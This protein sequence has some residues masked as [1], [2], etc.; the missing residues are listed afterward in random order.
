MQTNRENPKFL[1]I[2]P[3][4]ENMGIEYLSASLK[5]NNY[6][7]DLLFLPRPY[8]NTAFKIFNINEEKEMKKILKCIKNIKPDIICFSPYT[9]QYVWAIRTSS[10]I[11]KIF[12][13][14][15]IL[16]GGVHTTAVPESV[17][18]EKSVDAIIIGEAENSIIEFASKFGTKNIYSSASLWIKRNGTIK[19]NP[20]SKL[21][22]N[23]DSIPM[24]DKNIFYS[25]MPYFTKPSSYII[26]GSRGCPYSCSYCS[27]NVYRNLYKGQ[28]FV[29]FRS[30]ENIIKELR[31]AKTK[32]KI[33][34]VEFM[35]DVLVIEQERLRH[36]LRLYKKYINL[37]FSCFL[38]PNLLTEEI[39]FLL[40]NAK[41]TWLKM[42]IQSANEQYRKKYL[43]RYET[44]KDIINGSRLCKKYKLPFSFDHIFNLPGER[45]EHLIEAIKLYNKIKPTIINFGS[46]IYLPNTNIIYHALKLKILNNKDVDLINHGKEYAA[47]ISN[48][49]R[50][51]SK[52]S[53]N[54]INISVFALFFILINIFPK[55][56]IDFLMR[57]KFYNI[58]KPIPE[59]ILIPLKIVSKFSAKQEKLYISTIKNTFAYMFNDFFTYCFKK[60]H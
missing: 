59:I 47:N 21:Q 26:M 34:S 30:P 50:F 4:H 46:L 16:F 9:T 28:K 52:S 22:E 11:K 5:K 23:L 44:N 27:N 48:L 60:N 36:L 24:L 55:S 19:K 12:N 29:R 58:E 25:K 45:K 10:L 18:K 49:K 57:K 43:N 8:N 6:K 17:I 14:K 41:C 37:P 20:L 31:W 35:D 39:V 2:Q 3:E 38:H 32:Y 42:G 13:D 53:K 1:F 56:F 7:V 54:K 51:S 40:K 15:F 33:K